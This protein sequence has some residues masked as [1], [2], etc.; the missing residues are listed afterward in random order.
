VKNL[1]VQPGPRVRPVDWE[2]AAVGLGAWDLTR[3]IDGWGPEKPQ[4][5]RTYLEELER[6]LQRQ[7]DR[8]AFK[9]TLARC[10]VLNVLWHLR[11]SVEACREPTFVA[12]SLE[13]LEALGRRLEGEGRDG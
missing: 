6:Q 5:V 11:W 2:S 3:L 12:E 9:E 1:V 10:E 13:E 7:A 8:G 4:F